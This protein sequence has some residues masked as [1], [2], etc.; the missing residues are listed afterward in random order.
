MFTVELIACKMASNFDEIWTFVE[1]KL[2]SPV[3]S[4]MKYILSY[5][6]FNNAHTIAAINDDDI[7]YFVEEVKKGNVNKYYEHLV[8]NDVLEGSL[9]N[10]E[11][12]EFSRGHLKYLKVIVEHLKNH[13]KESLS[14]FSKNDC[15]SAVKRSIEKDESPIKKKLKM[16]SGEGSNSHSHSQNEELK[17]QRAILISKIIMS[18]VTNTPQ[19]YMK[20]SVTRLYTRTYYLLMKL[21]S[22]FQ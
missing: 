15:S 9:C 19:F 14:S 1:L 5:C 10:I 3:P 16:T 17:K 2:K 21:L 8:E 20:V 22:A 11:N 6:G 12:F 7:Q 4:Y 13:V 18:F